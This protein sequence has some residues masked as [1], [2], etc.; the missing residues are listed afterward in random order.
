MINA[1]S[2]DGK[3]VTQKQW[4]ENLEK[5]Y[6]KQHP[7]VELGRLAVEAIDT[8]DRKTEEGVYTTLPCGYDSPVRRDWYREGTMHPTQCPK[9]TWLKFCQKR[10]GLLAGEQNGQ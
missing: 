5:M 6:M 7:Y 3:K 4:Y 9:C 8:V 10:A 2:I 1:Y